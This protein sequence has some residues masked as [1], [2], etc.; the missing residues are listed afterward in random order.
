MAFLNTISS[1]TRPP[2]AAPTS[3]EHQMVRQRILYP[4][5]ALS[6]TFTAGN[7]EKTDSPICWK[8]YVGMILCGLKVKKLITSINIIPS[9]EHI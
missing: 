4:T 8:C 5:V 9:S 3:L 2:L 6:G 1:I 7:L